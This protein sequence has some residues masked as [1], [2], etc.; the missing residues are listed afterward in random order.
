MKPEAETS[1]EN[2]E[3]LL[4]SNN[5]FIIL[6]FIQKAKNKLIQNNFQWKNFFNFGTNFRYLLTTVQVV[7]Q[8]LHIQRTCLKILYDYFDSSL[9]PISLRVVLVVR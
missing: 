3:I 8:T 7:A 2:N 1:I 5:T 9:N 6:L 4:S